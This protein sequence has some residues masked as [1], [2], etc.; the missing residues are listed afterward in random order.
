MKTKYLICNFDH[1]RHDNDSMTIDSVEV[2]KCEAFCYLG[3]IIQ[4]NGGIKDDVDHRIKAGWMRWKMTFEVLCD[5]R[6]P[7][8]LK[9]KCYKAIVRPAMLY[10]T[11]C[12]ATTRANTHKMSVTEMHILR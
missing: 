2:S 12:W 11:E 8:K 5:K 9:A 10:A 7:I 3:F 1:D 4:R 6:V